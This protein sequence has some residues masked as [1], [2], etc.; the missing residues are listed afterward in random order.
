[1]G[2]D[3]RIA[4]CSCQILTIAVRDVLS[5]FG[6]AEA[7]GQT[8]VDDIYIVLLLADT[9]QEVVRFDVSVQE[10]TGV[11]EL[12]ALQLLQKVWGEYTA[13]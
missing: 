6:V 3:T 5:G 8:E 13:F 1:M 11:D 7:L 4:G 9:D 12:D 2:V 10:M